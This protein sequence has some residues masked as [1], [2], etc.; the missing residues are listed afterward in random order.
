[1]ILVYA[2][3]LG[4]LLPYLVGTWWYGTQKLSKEKVL[5]SSANNL[6][7]EYK[8]DIKEGTI[9]TATSVGT[10]FQEILKGEKAELGLAKLESK[11]LADG[12]LAVKDRNDLEDMDGGARRKALALLWAYLKRT[13]LDDPVLEREKFE[14]APVAHALN[15]SFTAIALAFGTTAPILAS[16]LTSQNLIQAVAPG[17]SPLLQLPYFTSAIAKAIEGDLARTHMSLQQY[18]SIPDA[19]RK[20]RSIGQGLLTEAQYNTAIA[21][22]KQLPRL[23]VEKAFFK[24]T[25][26]RYVTPGSLVTL[27]VKGRF[28]P[29]GSV[30][31]PEVNELDLEDVDAAE[32]DLDAIMGRKKKVAK[33]E[34]AVDDKPTQPPLVHAPYFA[35]EYS[36]RWHVYLTDSKQ[37][38]IAVPPFTFTTFDKP[39]YDNGTPTFN[40]QTL[41]AQ[42]QAPPGAGQYTFV[43]HLVCDSY[44]G[45]DTKME[46]TLNVEEQAKAEE[47]DDED[48]I[49]E[50]DEDTIAGA[51]AQMKNGGA[52][53][54]RRKKVVVQESSDDESNTDGEA[55]ADEDDGSDTDTDTDEE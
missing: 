33:G 12:G 41:R 52:S 53:P 8:E 50:P 5:I 4:V 16:Y 17:A 10:E 47:I 26:E 40:M 44:I 37:G 49:S 2:G 15:G 24:V 6:F 46:V 32:D 29:P 28:V 9:I 31:V 25:G 22:G 34:K 3:L 13:E 18:L 27:V 48:D 55:G 39:I 36:P 11:V 7:R 54:P 19:E 42:F 38:K 45:F 21:L 14:V 51:M 20:K 1:M 23:Q 30:N 35:R 43:M